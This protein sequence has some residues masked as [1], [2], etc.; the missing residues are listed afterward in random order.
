MITFFRFILVTLN[1]YFLIEK[2]LKDEEERKSRNSAKNAENDGDIKASIK[3]DKSSIKKIKPYE[4][5]IELK[6]DKY[7]KKIPHKV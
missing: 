4:E 6:D 1:N 7:F 5:I 2:Y 3:K